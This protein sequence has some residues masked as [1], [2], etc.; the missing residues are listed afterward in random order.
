MPESTNPRLPPDELAKLHFH[1]FYE[2]PPREY[3]ELPRSTRSGPAQEAEERARR[4][5]EE[6][7]RREAEKKSDLP[8]SRPAARLPRTPS[9][10][11]PR[12]HRRARSTRRPWLIAVIVFL[13]V[14]VVLE[15]VILIR[16]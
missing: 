2:E 7:A 5:A 9:A 12:S 10:E 3:R 13:V 11:R 16:G 15:V 1:G 4:E 14:L 8:W 6:E